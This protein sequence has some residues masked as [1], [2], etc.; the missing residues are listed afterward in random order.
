MR[1]LA[2]TLAHAGNQPINQSINQNASIAG[3]G[4]M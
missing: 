4:W 1:K 2:N 3:A